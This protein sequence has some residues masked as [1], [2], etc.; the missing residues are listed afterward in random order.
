MNGSYEKVV[1][2]T[3]RVLDAVAPTAADA[4]LAGTARRLYRLEG[5]SRE[6]PRS[7][8]HD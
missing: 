6:S 4:I 3:R 7:P 1:T 2:E 5:A 8:G